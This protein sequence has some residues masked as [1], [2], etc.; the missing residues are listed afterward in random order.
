MPPFKTRCAN[1]VHSCMDKRAVCLCAART[2]LVHRHAL[3]TLSRRRHR[4]SMPL[5]IEHEHATSA[6][7]CR[8]SPALTLTLSLSLPP[9][10]PLSL[11]PD[12]R[13]SA[14]TCPHAQSSAI[15]AHDGAVLG[16]PRALSI[17]YIRSAARIGQTRQLAAGNFQIL[18]QARTQTSAHITHKTSHTKQ[19][20][21]RVEHTSRTLWAPG[22]MLDG[23]KEG[24][25][26]NLKV[27]KILFIAPA[28]RLIWC[29]PQITG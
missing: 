10:L 24:G 25:D 9:S 19:C 6:P 16:R 20:T 12:R 29:S 11:P 17:V 26:F 27:C 1:S 3:D 8:R 28:V 5:S 22:L 13:G 4:G 18:G 2:T 23:S 14:G 15:C 21:H 7:G